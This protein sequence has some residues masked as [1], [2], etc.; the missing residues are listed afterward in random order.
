MVIFLLLNPAQTPQPKHVYETHESL[1]SLSLWS[2]HKITF[3]IDMPPKLDITAAPVATHWRAVEDPPTEYHREQTQ[4]CAVK[5]DKAQLKEETPST[6]PD[7]TTRPEESEE[8][9]EEGMSVHVCSHNVEIPVQTS[10]CTSPKVTQGV[11][12]YG[13]SLYVYQHSVT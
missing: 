9:D 12:M 4:L 8:P 13:N 5:L 2:C 1:R 6:L 3:I 7:S 11:R 10:V